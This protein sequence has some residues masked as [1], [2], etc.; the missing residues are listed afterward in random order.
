[1]RAGELFSLW[2]RTVQNEARCT[3]PTV[4]APDAPEL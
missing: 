4:N 1:M 2:S 3:G